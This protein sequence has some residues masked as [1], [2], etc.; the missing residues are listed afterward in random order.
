MSA[1]R[2]VEE[3]DSAAMVTAKRSA[4]IAPEVNIREHITYTTQPSVNKGALKPRGNVTRS[5]KQGYQWPH[6]KDLCRPIFFV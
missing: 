5:P 2:Y 4:G 1:R 6:K 3:N